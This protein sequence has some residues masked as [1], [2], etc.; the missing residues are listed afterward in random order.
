MNLFEKIEMFEKLAAELSDDSEVSEAIDNIETSSES[1]HLE[2]RNAIKF[3][4]KKLAALSG[5]F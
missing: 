5:R 3:R 1:N 2:R 4:M